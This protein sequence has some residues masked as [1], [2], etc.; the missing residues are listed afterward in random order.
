ML[1]SNT[2]AYTRCDIAACGCVT[3]SLGSPSDADAYYLYHC[4]ILEPWGTNNSFSMACSTTNNLVYHLYI[5]MYSSYLN[6]DITQMFLTIK[7]SYG[8]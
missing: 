5:E 7:C 3:D 1:E 8:N 2:A 4:L 6:T